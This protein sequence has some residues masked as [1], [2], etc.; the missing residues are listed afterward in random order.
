[1]ILFNSSSAARF[2]LRDIQRLQGGVMR[3]RQRWFVALVVVTIG[4]PLAPAQAS[5]ALTGAGTADH[6]T[7]SNF[8]GFS[9]GGYPFLGS[10]NLPDGT[11]AVGNLGNSQIRKFNDI[12]GQKSTNALLTIPTI[13]GGLGLFAAIDLANAG[14][15]AYA[16][17]N[18]AGSF[19]GFFQV[20]NDLSLTR[21]TPNL[22]A[23]P[24][25]GLAGNP[26]SGHLIATSNLGLIDLDPATGTD[27]VI[28]AVCPGV[29]ILPTCLPNEMTIFGDGVTVSPDGNTA[30]VAIFGESEVLGYD[31]LT[32]NLVFMATGLPDGP[33]GI[34]IISGG[35]LDGDIVVNNNGPTDIGSVGLIDVHT[36][37]PTETIIASGGTRGDFSSPDLNNGSLLVY[38]DDSAWRL[39]LAGSCIGAPC[40]GGG[41]G[42]PEPATLVLL[43][44]GLLSLGWARR[45]RA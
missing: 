33:D 23:L 42:L 28:I 39:A 15:Q 40:P 44:I 37:I 10:A 8:L 24:T 36:T 35:A 16:A 3:V 43:S 32:G 29:V 1:L 34:A 18:A 12:D 45:R 14:G 4:A 19:G 9:G 2:L 25:H 31:I 7:L 17:V 26:V 27:R 20:A 38:E 6:F 21:I 13:P 11:L 22:L 30:Y 5:L 41:P